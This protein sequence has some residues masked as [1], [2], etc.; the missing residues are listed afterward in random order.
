MRFLP[1]QHLS[2][3][4]IHRYRAQSMEVKLTFYVALVIRQSWKA[5]MRITCISTYISWVMEQLPAPSL[6]PIT[7]IL[8][9][10]VQ[11]LISENTSEPI[12]HYIAKLF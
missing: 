10:F 5:G 6:S 12:T 4:S 7:R 8:G 11:R 9:S 3:G 1:E 2:C